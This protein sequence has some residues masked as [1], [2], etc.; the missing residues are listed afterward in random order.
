MSW[1]TCWNT[2]SCCNGISIIENWFKNRVFGE[3]WKCV[4][5]PPCIQESIGLIDES[6]FDSSRHLP[7]NCF[8]MVQFCDNCNVTYK[9]IERA[10]L[11]KHSQWN[12]V[13]ALGLVKNRFKFSK[14]CNAFS[15]L[16]PFCFEPFSG[17]KCRIRWSFFVAKKGACENRILE[18][19]ETSEN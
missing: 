3:I 17:A 13:P 19:A 15:L 1:P 4:I 18:C 6:L 11:F 16:L 8:H 14:V 10:V 12:P 2:F 9:L 7:F 5:G